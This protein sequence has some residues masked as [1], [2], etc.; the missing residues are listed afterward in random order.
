MAE[1]K[2][3]LKLDSTARLDAL[4]AR[5]DYTTAQIEA[6]AQR[7]EG[8]HGSGGR[9]PTK[10]QIIKAERAAAWKQ[11]LGKR[12]LPPARGARGGP[13]TGQPCGQHFI[14]ADLTC[15]KGA[16]SPPAARE[17]GSAAAAA[18]VPSA[19]SS[20]PPA[21]PPRLSMEE[22]RHL[23]QSVDS[24]RRPWAAGLK[25]GRDAADAYAKGSSGAAG[26][27]PQ[28]R[29]DRGRGQRPGG[30]AD[31]PTPGAGDAANYGS[32]QQGNP[33]P[34]GGPARGGRTDP[35]PPAFA[36]TVFASWRPMRAMP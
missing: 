11:S 32:G 8:L 25:P 14:A 13:G 2:Q 19:G 33:R 24:W 34:C 27:A 26:P 29:A 23:Q 9:M 6:M 20:A 4:E 7:R 10:D 18:S 12:G 22:H 31:A 15:H 16:G 35:L 17:G 21:E 28:R 30:A 5:L 36:G 1:P 3:A